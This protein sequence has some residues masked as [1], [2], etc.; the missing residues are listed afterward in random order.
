MVSFHFCPSCAEVLYKRD[1]FREKV[2]AHTHTH[3]YKQLYLYTRSVLVPKSIHKCVIRSACSGLFPPPP[4]PV[5]LSLPQKGC[6]WAPVCCLRGKEISLGHTHHVHITAS[7]RW[8]K[9]CVSEA[10][11]PPLDL[12]IPPVESAHVNTHSHSC[13]YVC[14]CPYPG[15]L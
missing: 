11:L 14:V 4:C 7:I 15:R 13:T 2:H 1:K 5:H 10:L 9:P 8:G 12:S 3:R 6:W